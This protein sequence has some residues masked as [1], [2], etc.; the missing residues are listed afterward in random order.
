MVHFMNALRAL[1]AADAPADPRKAARR[2]WLHATAAAW[3]DATRRCDAAWEELVADLPEDKIDEV[4][5]PPPPEQAEV[6]ALWAKL[7]AVIER[8]EWPR[9]LYWGGI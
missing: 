6:D 4:E 9:E 5:L 3:Q 7:D 1:L 2:S 8:D